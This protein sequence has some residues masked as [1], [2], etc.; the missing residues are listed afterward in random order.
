MIHKVDLVDLR[1][2][3]S[4]SDGVRCQRPELSAKICVTVCALKLLKTI[5]D[6]VDLCWVQVMETQLDLAQPKHRKSGGRE[7]LIGSLN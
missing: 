1:A 2:F 7:E 4:A 6:S 5:Q 3:L